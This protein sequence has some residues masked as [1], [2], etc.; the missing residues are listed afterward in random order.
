MISHVAMCL[1][2]SMTM[3]ASPPQFTAGATIV[4]S[5][6]NEGSGVGVVGASVSITALDRVART[7]TIGGFVLDSIPPGTWRVAASAKGFYAHEV[8]VLVPATGLVRLNIQL[9]PV[10][11]QL[12]E[13]EVRSSQRA[14]TEGERARELFDSHLLPAA[15]TVARR[16]MRALPTIVE[17]DVL[18]TL[19]TL[20]GGVVLNDLDAQLYVRGG[21][22]DQSAFFLDGA[23]VFAP[24]HMFGMQGVF[25]PDA[26]ERIDF[27]RGALP[28][29]YSGVLS[30]IVELE[31]AD[32]DSLTSVDAGIS[33]VGGRFAARGA[34]PND[35]WR[36][37]IGGRRTH[38][39]LA[40]GNSIPYAYQDAQTRLTFS[41]APSHSVT[42]SAFTSSDRFRL[43]I[44]EADLPSMHSSW[45]NASGSLRWIWRRDGWSTTSTAWGSRYRAVIHTGQ[46]AAARTTSDLVHVAA[47]RV[48]VQHVTGASIRRFGAEL[49]RG[50]VDLD[51]SQIPG[52]YFDDRVRARILRPAT[53]AEYDRRIGR[54]RVS[55]AARGRRR[56]TGPGTLL[57]EPEVSAR[58]QLTDDVSLT[59][60]VT[61]AYQDLSM[62][63][64]ERHVLPGPPLWFVHP[65]DQP[66]SRADGATIELDMWR[67]STWNVVAS[68]Y[69]RR[70]QDV[71]HWRP[72]GPRTLA[73]I[74]WDDG[75]ADGLELGVRRFGQRTS[76]WF[77]YSIGHSRFTHAPDG[78]RYDPT[79]DRRHAASATLLATPWSRVQLSLQTQYGTGR[80]FWP[81]VGRTFAPTLDPV[82]G[83]TIVGTTHIY[84]S[85]QLRHHAYARTDVGARTSF[86]ALG[87]AFEPYVNLQNVNRR[88]NV[89][90][91]E[92]PIGGNGIMRPAAMP[93]FFLPTIGLDVRF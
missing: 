90:Y 36:W 56:S 15:T 89:M 88:P 51:G 1:C 80:P 22:P 81:I 57:F 39:D 82:T 38:A 28:V 26:V 55:A 87:A 73:S 63:R 77:G 69:S 25:N 84:G 46:A 74:S 66:V 60:G 33:M 8:D 43:D 71:P 70:M 16:E 10:P 20:A 58:V 19:Q 62:L 68:A 31:Q 91:Y 41:P 64:E 86:H 49:E 50:D 34:G 67:G 54:A 72:A 45:A 40:F 47:L 37:A 52:G 29:R 53:Y 83:G 78:S 9:R 3:S 30:A 6:R 59:T 76:G 18:R 12:E 79:W 13:I 14:R 21:A 93:N 23:R 92:G 61:R 24:H 32:G 35:R 2:A 27:Y 11:Q 4:G 44:D 42:A 85:T 5:V 75:R 7:D 65:G 48:D 17:P